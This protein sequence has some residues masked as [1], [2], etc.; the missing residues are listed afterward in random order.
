[1]KK[2]VVFISVIV[3]LITIAGCTKTP[4]MTTGRKLNMNISLNENVLKK[5]SPAILT[6]TMENSSAEKLVLPESLFMIEFT[7]YSGSIKK[8]F[9]IDPFGDIFSTEK[10]PYSSFEM[11]GNSKLSGRIDLGKIVFSSV[12]EDSMLLPNDD[13]TVN[14]IISARPDPTIEMNNGMIRSNYADIQIIG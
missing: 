8:T 6:L 5:D 2:C 10:L 12:G 1:M 13:Y 3:V 14:L 9:Y 4:E 7:S 11:E